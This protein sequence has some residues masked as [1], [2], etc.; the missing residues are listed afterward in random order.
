MTS[1]LELEGAAYKGVLGGQLIHALFAIISCEGGRRSAPVFVMSKLSSTYICT[2][3]IQNH[4]EAGLGRSNTYRN[5]KRAAQSQ[6][7]RH[8]PRVNQPTRFQSVV[9]LTSPQN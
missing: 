5:I 1:E 2:T 6:D 7:T 3:R 9:V 4:I 8:E